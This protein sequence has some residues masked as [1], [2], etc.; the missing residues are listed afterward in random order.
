MRPQEHPLTRLHKLRGYIADA[1]HA[2][3]RAPVEVALALLTA[4]AFS[5][6][7]ESDRSW[8]EIHHL[9]VA[10]LSALCAAWAGTITHALGA[11]A[12]RTRWIITLAGAAF[13][14]AYLLLTPD[15]DLASE[16]W[17]AF[18]LVGAALLF[19]F[20][21]P[22][23]VRSRDDANLRLRRVNARLFLR[24]VGIILYGVALFAG[25]AL[26]LA[27]VDNLFELQLDHEIYG[28][29]FV[30]IMLVLVPWVIA[31]GLSDYVRPLD[32]QSEVARVV[33]RL[34]TWLVP[35]L[36]AIYLTILYVYAIRI[37]VTGELPKNLVSPMVIAAGLLTLL[38]LIVFDPPPEGNATRWLRYP[39]L[40]YLPL[41]PLGFWALFVRF[42]DYGFTEF[43]LL[44]IIALI[45]ILALAV[46]MAVRVLKRRSLPLPMIP[47]ALGAVL[48]LSA[49]G[50]WNVLAVS[51]RDQQARLA[52]AL[53]QAG[54]DLR[55]APDPQDTTTRAIP[56]ALYNRIVDLSYYL[57]SHFGEESLTRVAAVYPGAIHERNDLAMHFGLRSQYSDSVTRQ[58]YARFGGAQAAD[59]AAGRAYRIEIPEHTPQQHDAWAA[60]D[61]IFIRIGA[62]TL[63]ADV[64]PIYGLAGDMRRTR[65]RPQR[66]LQALPVLDRTGRKRGDLVLLELNFM[67][68]NGKREVPRVDAVL[69]LER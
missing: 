30:W 44:R 10:A 8:P 28:H 34:A 41:A 12:I 54:V 52:D 68:Q 26:A 40:L 27:A 3:D 46:V 45:A 32:E 18:M 58:M 22:A 21:A 37:V 1:G 17:R 61:S 66:E 53:E 7:I 20:S 9:L 55:I 39:P 33:Y 63:R 51:E 50:P 23:M 67:E 60:A 62:D 65:V 13:A 69:V 42:S 11:I 14:A 47:V 4:I 35:L 49:I 5:Y 48:V 29:V 59:I 6:G 31:G 56:A 25:L 2:L 36:V 16:H 38:A 19:A 64:A 24:A 15:F 43:R 57:Q